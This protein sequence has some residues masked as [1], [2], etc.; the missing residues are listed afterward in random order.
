[1]KTQKKTFAIILV[2]L[3]TSVPLGFFSFAVLSAAETGLPDYE[4]LRLDSSFGSRELP[5][6]G[7][8][9]SDIEAAGGLHSSFA[10]GDYYEVG[11]IE[12][13]L[14]LD[15]YYGYYYWTAFQLRAMNDLAEVWVQ[16][17]LSYGWDIFGGTFSD[18]RDDP[19][20]SQEHIDYLLD[21]FTN[22]IYPATTTYFGVPDSHDGNNGYWPD[23]YNGSSRE[24][25]LVHNFKDDAYYDP[26]YPYYIAGFYSSTFET[27]FDRNIINID[28]HDWENRVG[29]DAARTNLYESIIAHEYQH[30]IHDDYNTND[31]SWMNEACSMFA[32]VLSG[33][34]VD[35]GAI[36]R[37]LFTPDNS[38]TEWGDQGARNILADYGSSFLWAMYLNDHYGGAAFLSQFVQGG[39]PGIA[40]IEA[41]L[42]LLGYEDD[43]IDVFH[44]WRIA[45]LIDGDGKYG[46]ESIDLNPDTNPELEGTGLTVHEVP[47]KRI[48]WTYA[49]MEF[50]TT[51]SLDGDDTGISGVSPLGSDYISFPDARGLNKFQ[52]KGDELAFVPVDDY[53][54]WTYDGEEWYSGMNSLTNSIIATP[55]HVGDNGVLRI[56]TFWDIEDEWDFAFVQVSTTGG[57]WESDWTSLELAGV[58]TYVID[59]S[60]HPNAYAHL[61]GFYGYSGVYVD[62]EFDLS[63]YA[64][65]DIHIGFRY[66]TDWAFEYEGWYLREVEVSDDTGTY[67]I[68]ADLTPVYPAFP[69]ADF[70]VSVVTK[71][72]YRHWDFVCVNDIPVNVEEYGKTLIF[73]TR[74]IE[75][76]V[77][78][79]PISYEGYADYQF[80]VSRLW[81]R[82]R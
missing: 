64:G 80:K 43:F 19:V 4:P 23:Y 16:L 33:Y 36:R 44:D 50:G 52:F 3:F 12:T 31:P 46:Y 18:P 77:V 29:D 59:P 11:D 38:L 17:N 65:M 27:Y 71:F 21:E 66:V 9:T 5:I 14:S 1:M 62:L 48:P 39:I 57:A 47:G 58:T 28:S 2:L 42:D 7:Q 34:P 26:D 49:G 69:E 63:A 32:E 13:W 73:D 81:G 67:D 82:F 56:N 20:V 78:V 79:T 74:K 76:I 25:I 8:R 40:G 55:F 41:T 51:W 22:T 75:T 53:D 6:A 35:Y 45:N 68:E 30:L 10:P 70:M 54:R 15:D 72:S 60:G 61:P 37:F 24:V